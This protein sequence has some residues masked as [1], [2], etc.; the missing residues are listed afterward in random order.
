MS[1]AS[2]NFIFAQILFDHFYLLFKN[3]TL[4]QPMSKHKFNVYV[5]SLLIRNAFL[6]KEDLKLNCGE[7]A[8]KS[9]EKLK[10]ILNVVSRDSSKLDGKDFLKLLGIEIIIQ[11]DTVLKYFYQ[12]DKKSSKIG[13][14]F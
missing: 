2:N 4:F 3:D 8:S 12:M 6:E 5:Q 13:V 14:L 9:Y 11:E 7:L 1:T 10:K